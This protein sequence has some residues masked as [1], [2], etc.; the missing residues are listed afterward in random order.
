MKIFNKLSKVIFLFFT[1]SVLALSACKK[2][3]PDVVVKG[4]AK[5]KVVN[6]TL[7]EIEQDVYLDNVKVTGVALAFGETSDYIKIPSGSRSVAYIGS[8]S[9][10]NT[11]ASFNFTPAITYTAFLVANKSNVREIVSYEDNLSNSEMDKAKVKLINLSPNFPTGINVSVQAGLQF[12]NGLAYKEASGY[13]TVDA[14]LNLR[15][16]VVG[17]GNIKTI[18]N[19]NFV[20]G[21]IYTIWFSG[22]TAANLEA[23]IITD[24]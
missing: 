4:E 19:S 3:D 9:A 15:Y 24:N 22:T 18:D 7:T 6:A 11:N 16:S 10:N 1:V 21:K 17:S 13:F 20:G 2:D 12:V 14:G 8:N 5:I 23:H